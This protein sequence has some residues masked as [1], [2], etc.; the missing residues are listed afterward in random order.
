MTY[1]KDN[2]S[3][4]YNGK[5]TA[6]ELVAAREYIVAK[7]AYPTPALGT[8]MVRVNDTIKA[9]A[10]LVYIEEVSG[11]WH[12]VVLTPM[13][14][15]TIHFRRGQRDHQINWVPDGYVENTHLIFWQ[16]PGMFL[17]D[18]STFVAA[19]KVAKT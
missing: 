17:T 15:D 6:N 14:P 2:L 4:W 12:G 16:P 18:D 10:T 1:T 9:K 5:K 13:G 3:T 7:L 8:T 19:P 11:G